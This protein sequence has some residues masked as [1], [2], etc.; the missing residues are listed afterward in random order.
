M[1]G[2]VDAL[3]PDVEVSLITTAGSP[4]THVK[5][6]GGSRRA[7]EGHLLL[8]TGHRREPRRFTD[9][10][11]EYSKTLEKD[12]KD[13][14]LTYS[15][16]FLVSPWH[17]DD[18]TQYQ[19]NETQKAM[20]SIANNGGRVLMVSTTTQ[21]A[22]AEA[23]DQMKN[24]RQAVI[25]GQLAKVSRGA[26]E[27]MQDFTGMTS[28]LAEWGKQL[29]AVHAKQIAQYR[30]TLERPASASGQLNPQNLELR[31]T[32]QGVNGSVSGDGRF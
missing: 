1:N 27:P 4:R 2:F 12:V 3:P 31:I 8:W 16:V 30:V 10:I 23:N 6:D 25:G 13:K 5:F 9:S 22:N 18:V 14:K 24:G 7:Q 11:V 26:F 29:G 32:R 15:P 21:V 17:G 20:T 19:P 28:T